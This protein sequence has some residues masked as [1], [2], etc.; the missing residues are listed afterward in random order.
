M[1][2]SDPLDGAPA[3]MVGW[4]EEMDA[5]EPLAASGPGEIQVRV[6]ARDGRVVVVALGERSEDARTLIKGM[7]LRPEFLR[8]ILCG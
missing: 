5:G 8:R 1:S 2:D 6:V 4:L 3:G 7:G